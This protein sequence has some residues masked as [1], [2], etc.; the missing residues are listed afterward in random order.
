MEFFAIEGGVPLR[1][2]VSVHGSKNS[3]LPILAAC[4]L[5]RGESVIHNCP[6]L[7]DIAAA[8]EILTL[9]GCKVRRQGDTV[10]VD[11]T[12]SSGCSVPDALM[13]EMR[14]SVLFLGSLLASCGQADACWPGGCALGPRPIDLH[15][16]ALKTLGAEISDG[17]GRL[18]CR[19]TRLTGGR[20]FLPFPSVGA[21]ENAML[22]ACGAQGVTTIENAAREPEIADLQG[23]LRA[24][25]A[26]VSGGG[27]SRITVQGGTPLFPG[28]YMVMSD[29][30]V[31]A[32]YLAA[33]AAAGGEAELLQADGRTVRPVLEAL[34]AAGCTI[35]KERNRL[36]I[37]RAGPLRGIGELVT[38]PYPGFPTDAQP[39]LA[40]ALAGG[41][42]YTRLTETIFSGRFG[43][44][45][46]LCR[47]GA[48]IR[49]EGN[50]AEIIGVGSLHGACTQSGDLRGGAALT[51]AALGARGRSEIRNLVHI[52]RGYVRLEQ[53]LQALGGRISREKREAV[54]GD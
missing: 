5:A 21:T 15:L 47:M 10:T 39:L 14:A 29:R 13:R 53:A 48:K 16:K 38:R 49:V 19:G 18:H 54:Q 44:T 26:K 11:T 37:R 4:L 27:T 22:A 40:A 12:N 3:A 2:C 7:T 43:Y 6:D 33:V 45:E 35:G 24:L 23:F 31:T 25:G 42:G 30:I 46:Q 8:M 32:T 52:D 17:R 20:I 41:T 50:T 34:T 36:I 28:E 1:G 9:L 51:V